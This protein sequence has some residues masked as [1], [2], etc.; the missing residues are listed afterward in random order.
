VS[1]KGSAKSRVNSLDFP[2]VR[3]K[4]P[5]SGGQ[6]ASPLWRTATIA[7]PMLPQGRS[8]GRARGPSD[9]LHH[10]V[11]LR[12]GD[13][14]PLHRAHRRWCPAGTREGAA[15]LRALRD[16]EPARGG[17]KA[18]GPIRVSAPPH[19]APSAIRRRLKGR[20]ARKLCAACPV[21]QK[22]DWGRHVWA[23]GACWAPVAQRTEEMGQA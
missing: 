6:I 2:R 18:Q 1:E 10:R 15:D 23:R 3:F 5:P 11:A 22:R 21:L 7:L 4:P 9:R 17:S 12:M 16:Q 20:T 14:G 19:M 8:S 13:P